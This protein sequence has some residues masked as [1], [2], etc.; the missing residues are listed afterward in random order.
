MLITILDGY[1]DEPSRLGVPPYIS[2]Y[3]RYL[4]G[5]ISDAG[6][7]YEYMTIDHLRSGSRPKGQILTII[8]GAIVPGK[9]LRSMP[10]SRKE[11]DRI[12]KEV[13]GEAIVWSPA[14]L[15]HSKGGICIS[16]C[17]PDAFVHDFLTTGKGTERRRL[18]EEWSDWAVKGAGL[19]AQHQDHP[20]PLIV[21]LDLSY[22]C[23]RYISGGCSFCTEPLYGEPVFRSTQ[24]I[25]AE[26]R[27]LLK[28]GCTNFR[29]GGQSCIMSYMAEGIGETE[30]PKPNVTVMGEL[31][32]GIS[33]LGGIRVLHTDNA[34]P[35]IIARHPAESARILKMIVNTCTGGNVLSLG[36]ESTDPE[37]V[38]KN[39]LNSTPD[40]ALSAIRLI[41]RIG[42]E[43]GPTGLPRLLPGLNFIAGLKGETG[44]TYAHNTR[45]LMNVLGE[46]LMLRRINIRQV[47]GTRRSFPRQRHRREFFAF[48]SFVRESI[49]RPMLER[50]APAGTILKNAF[51]EL[52]KGKLTF[53]R[54]IG[55]YPLLIGIP[56]DIGIGKFL[57][58]RVTDHGSRSLTAV[59]HP[60]DINDCQMSALEALPSIGR[61]RA[62]RIVRARPLVS[63]EELA[64]AL[65]D[66]ELAEEIA[67]HFT[68][69]GD[70]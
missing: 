6:H 19:V 32:R 59:E 3:P 25:I 12:L 63:V 31:F 52:I 15:H 46:G 70:E 17:D 22:G 24:S 44:E 33:E 23:S 35:G 18:P 5:A 47:A 57:N 66:E 14:P 7:E 55:T 43:R 37:V 16:G 28:Q 39:N 13:A 56:Q 64:R 41:N 10:M 68:F 65:E 49:D 45:F 67:E 30:T 21:E 26:L 38:G 62:A 11:L 69:G 34:N 4:A 20:Q 61:K 50:V 36:I 29:L 1:V 9:Y 42:S 2:P 53:A 58:V 54:Q 51:T 27:A 8:F 40:D 60:L 48:K